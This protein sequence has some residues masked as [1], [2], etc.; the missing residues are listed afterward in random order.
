[1]TVLHRGS[2]ALNRILG[3]QTIDPNACYKRTEY[4]IEAQ[5]EDGS[6]Y[7]Y[8]TMTGAL[9]FLTPD[10][11]SFWNNLT[12]DCIMGNSPLLSNNEQFVSLWFVVDKDR[13]ERSQVIQLRDMFSTFLSG[14]TIKTYTI[15]T[16]TFCNAR[17]F[18]CFESD[19]ARKHM[20]RETADDVIEYICGN[21][22]GEPILIRWFGGEPLVNT[23]VIDYISDALKSRDVKFTSRIVSNGSLFSDQVIEQSKKWNL[24]QAMITIDGL[25]DDYNR[26][27]QYVDP[28]GDPFKTVTDNIE[29]LLK[30]GIFVEIRLNIDMHNLK[31]IP[32]ILAFIADRYKRYSNFH[33]ITQL[34]HENGKKASS[35]SLDDRKR[36]YRGYTDILKE[37]DRLGIGNKDFNL[38]CFKAHACM[39]DAWDNVVINPNGEISKCDACAFEGVV[40][41]LKSGIVDTKTWTKSRPEISIC[42]KCALYPTCYTLERCEAYLPCDETE[43]Q[44][45]MDVLEQQVIQK[46]RL[47][48]M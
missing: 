2:P 10:E 39:A 5:D 29:A 33:V 40:G 30:N 22:K 48:R 42:E 23:R 4:F 25:Y 11:Y 14:R 6:H 15:L 45:K 41:T 24:T 8:N 9:L 27:K 19:Y 7:L 21:Y 18:Y 43:Q 20:D 16:T 38:Q 46:A 13:D 17:C 12:N 36:L 35:G 31:D 34:L 3:E 1:M 32:E 37:I 44:F 28:N 26:I 47:E